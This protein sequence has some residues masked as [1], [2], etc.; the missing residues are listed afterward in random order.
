MYAN[1][2]N[3]LIWESR[4]GEKLVY[5]IPDPMLPYINPT[6]TPVIVPPA[7]PY[8]YVY[9]AKSKLRPATP[10]DIERLGGQNG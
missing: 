7:K 2:I 5:E 9:R 6:H 1:A 8:A 10:A 4:R 3:I